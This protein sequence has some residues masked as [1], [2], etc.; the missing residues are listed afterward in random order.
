MK[1]LEQ[2]DRE[3]ITIIYLKD[4]PQHN[5]TNHFSSNQDQTHTM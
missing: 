5:V 3:K 2:K 4:Q 1:V